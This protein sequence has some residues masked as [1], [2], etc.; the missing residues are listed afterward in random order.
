[1][2]APTP[3]YALH[4]QKAED[5][6]GHGEGK[7]L[8]AREALSGR[9]AQRTAAGGDR[10]SGACEPRG[11]YSNV[12]RL[13]PTCFFEVLVLPLWQKFACLLAPPP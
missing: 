6:E 11:D 1:M 2:D 9:S 12:T 10:Y 4:D 5:H 8:G 3:E 7:S 13:I